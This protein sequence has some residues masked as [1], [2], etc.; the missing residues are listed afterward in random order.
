VLTREMVVRNLSKSSRT[1]SP[2]HRAVVAATIAVSLLA[3]AGGSAMGAGPFGTL[4]LGSEES[5]GAAVAGGYDRNQTRLKPGKGSFQS[6]DIRQNQFYV[7]LQ[8]DAFGWAWSGRLGMADFGDGKDFQD[9]FRPFVG[10][11]VKG[12]LYGSP[13]TPFEVVASLQ[14][15]VYMKY[16]KGGVTVEPAPVVTES[17]QVKDYWDFGAG[18]SAQRRIRPDLSVYGGPMFEY[19]EAKVYRQRDFTDV[20]VD[21]QDTYFKSSPLWGLFGGVVWKLEKVNL[22][23]EARFNG[24]LSVGVEAA[25][26]F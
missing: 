12:F 10:L 5:Q 4:S 6:V 22:N 15:S 3:L 25:Y 16:K 13:D 24:N 2:L 18:V 19:A 1:K 21:R 26:G 20:S 7:Q 14:T 23:A 17:F 9:G 11:G 8:D